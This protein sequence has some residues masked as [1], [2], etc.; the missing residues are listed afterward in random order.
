MLDNVHFVSHFTHICDNLPVSF[1]ANFLNVVKYFNY[2]VKSIYSPFNFYFRF[3]RK[4]SV[5]VNLT[6]VF[7]L[8]R[9]P[10]ASNNRIFFNAELRRI[11]NVTMLNCYMKLHQQ[12]RFQVLTAT[13]KNMNGFWC[14]A[15]CSFVKI[16]RCLL[17]DRS[18]SSV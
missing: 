4:Y 15:P 3:C 11:K 16:N 5:C 1:H 6:T 7:C 13:S 2:F 18:W 17:T 14:V 9:S 10:I 12:L 8:H